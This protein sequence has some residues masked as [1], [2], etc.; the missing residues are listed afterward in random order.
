[1]EKTEKKDKTKKG[2]SKLPFSSKEKTIRKG[3]DP[4]D[5]NTKQSST[6]LIESE[7]DHAQGMQGYYY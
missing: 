7:S 1:M 4:A 3:S 6:T 5:V 2:K